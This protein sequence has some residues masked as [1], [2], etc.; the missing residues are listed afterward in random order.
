MV[1]VQELYSGLVQYCKEMGYL[2]RAFGKQDKNEVFVFYSDAKDSNRGIK[3]LLI[4][5]SGTLYISDV[6]FTN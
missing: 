5:P 2:P 3:E 4:L 1:I 6:I